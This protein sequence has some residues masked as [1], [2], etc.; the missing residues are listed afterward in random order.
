MKPASLVALTCCALLCCAAYAQQYPTRPIRIVVPY[1]PGGGIDIVVRAIHAALSERLRQPLVIDNR[2]GATG[3]IGTELVARAVPDGYTLLAHTSAGLTIAPHLNAQPRYD[4][5]RDFAPITL[6]ASSPFV[7]VVHPQVAAASVPQLIALA[8]SRPGELNYSSSGNGS[9]AHLAGLLLCKLAGV[10]LVHVPYKGGGPAVTALVA[11]HVQT[12]FSSIPPAL[13]HVRSGRLRALATT[14]ATRFGLLPELPT[15]A[16]SLP[17]FVVDSWSA[18]LAPAGT[19]PAIVGKL[20]SEIVAVLQTADAKAKL[21]ADGSEAVGSTPGRL[22]EIMKADLARWGPLVRE[23][24][25]R[26][27]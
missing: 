13:P 6:V 21:N 12:R 24:G 25:A 17:G 14:G 18:I 8:K 10:S 26:N 16:E 20:N 1:P 22:G 4:T 7:L 11:G 2:G 23:A 15:V 5:I 19:P 9:S 27:D 3:A